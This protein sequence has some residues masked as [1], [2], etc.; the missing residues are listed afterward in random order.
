MFFVD[1][2]DISLLDSLGVLAIHFNSDVSLRV[3]T[4]VVQRKELGGDLGYGI[5]ISTKPLN[6]TDPSVVDGYSELLGCI[7]KELKVIKDGIENKK[8]GSS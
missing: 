7:S 4:I 1:D 6:F 8:G 3:A 2:Y 5:S